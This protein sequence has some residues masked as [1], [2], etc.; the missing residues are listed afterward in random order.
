MLVKKNLRRLKQEK[1]WTTKEMSIHTG[2]SEG[3]LNSLLSL[4]VNKVP[5]VY[6]LGVLC[7]AANVPIEYFFKEMD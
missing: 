1:S 5:T 6:M 4:K 2:I 3:Y 7:E